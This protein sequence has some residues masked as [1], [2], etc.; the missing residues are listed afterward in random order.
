[1]NRSEEIGSTV[2]DTL[3]QLPSPFEIPGRFILIPKPPLPLPEGG[4]PESSAG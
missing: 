1:M 4:Y 3:N 2:N